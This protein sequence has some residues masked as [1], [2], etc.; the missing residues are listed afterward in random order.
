MYKLLAT[1]LKDFRILTRDK[2]GLSLMFIMPIVL[3]LVITSLQ[4]STFE[5][6]NDNKIKLVICDKDHK[7]ASNLFVNALKQSNMFSITFTDSSFTQDK[8]ATFMHE[9]DG[10]VAILIPANFT[11]F[12]EHKA[13]EV[14]SKALKDF[15]ISDEVVETKKFNSPLTLLYHPVLQDSYKKSIIGGINTSM[16]MIQ[17]KMILKSMYST[18]SSGDI[19]TDLESQLVN[20]RIKINEVPIS[21]DGSSNIPNATQHNIP[22]W[23]I[24]A[25]FFVV[26]SLGSSIVKEKNSG[27]FIR[28]KTLPTNYLIA[29]LSK[30]ITYIGVCLLQVMVIFTMG[31][32]L[33]PLIDLPQLVLPTNIGMLLLVSFICG[34][35][36]VSYAMLIGIFAQSQ[37]QANGFGAVSIVLLAAIGGILVPSFAMPSSFLM[38]MKISPL[39]WCLESYYEIILEGG[40]F[41][42]LF[43]NLY[44][45][46]IIILILQLVTY[47]RLKTNNLI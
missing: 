5:L 43:Q 39:H 13:N 36:A 38:I 9:N 31:N 6:V 10:L 2:V 46:L 14:S 32:L 29:L 44:P 20:N 17:T 41:F 11:T 8:V 28:L 12:I 27:S 22:A 47:W 35:C 16:Q 21:K 34:W 33:F 37:E 26:T 4:V 23:T 40:S 18:L 3:A 1:I 19:P 30:Q 7:E 42:D 24:F 45:L 25:M 15:G